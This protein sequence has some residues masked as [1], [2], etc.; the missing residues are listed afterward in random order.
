M[1][2]ALLVMV[3]LVLGLGGLVWYRG[4]TPLVAEGLRAGWRGMGPVVPLVLVVVLLSGFV[5]VLLPRETVA[6][7]LSDE[8]GVRGL[9]VAW[10][11]GVLTPGGGPVGLPIAAALLRNGAGMG[12]LVTYLT[13]MSLL[14]F[15]RLPMEL[16]IYGPRLTAVRVLASAALPL[17]AGGLAQAVERWL[18]GAP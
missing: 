14:S 6:R 12:V 11:A 9:G 1:R 16:G 4:G 18:P 8:A 15:V 10:L 3:A 2:A 13:S 7:W 5:E 17:L